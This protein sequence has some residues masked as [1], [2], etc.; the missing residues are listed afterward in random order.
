[1]HYNSVYH[2]ITAYEKNGV[3]GLKDR[4]I[5]GRPPLL[6]NAD[7][8][9]VEAFIRATPQQPKVVLARIEEELG[10]SISRDTLKRT[11]KSLDHTYRRV[12]KS[13]RSK[14]NDQQFEEKK[15]A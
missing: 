5:R 4:P 1:M 11:L 12:K 8:R 13:L 7:K 9:Q 6:S 15:R 2:W 10:K 3:S 14:R